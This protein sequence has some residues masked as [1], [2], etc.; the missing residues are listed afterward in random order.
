MIATMWEG[1]KVWRKL[2]FGPVELLFSFR[3]AARITAGTSQDRRVRDR[4]SP[5]G[6]RNYDNSSSRPSAS[7]AA[8]RNASM[9]TAVIV[10]AGPGFGY[11]LANKLAS[12]GF[13]LAL[14]SRDANRLAPLCRDLREHGVRAE[15]YGGDVTHEADV[16]CVFDQ[17]VAS[18]GCPSLVVYSLQESGPGE[19]LV[20]S[21][22]AF[23]SAW[24]HNC[25]GA[26]LVSQAAGRIMKTNGKGSI[27]LIGSTS[28]VLG[29]AGHLNLAV[30]KFG[31]R[32]LAQVMGRELWPF[33]IHVAHVLI[34][35]DIAESALTSTVEP[36]SDPNDIAIS[37]LAL[38]Q[39]PRSAWSSEIDLRPWNEAFWE[40]C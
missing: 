9:G 24:R 23:E 4:A 22:P 26:F 40:H 34:D 10:G 2:R 6:R 27:F 7:A 28:S 21:T 37:I 33:G 13:N 16:Q 25:F 17:I 32:A 11:A 20:I 36:Q 19:T 18:Q 38:H 39:Q 30:G 3:R 35:A 31:Q 14:V 15:S 29:R 5:S 1:M 8:P 12:S